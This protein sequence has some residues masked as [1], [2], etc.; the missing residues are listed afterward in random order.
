MTK[1]TNTTKP[2]RGETIVTMTL[3][4]PPALINAIAATVTKAIMAAAPRARI[5]VTEPTRPRK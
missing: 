2:K 3:Q 5:D 1:R 4:G